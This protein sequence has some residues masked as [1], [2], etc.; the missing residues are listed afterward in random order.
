MLKLCNAS[1]LANAAFLSEKVSILM[2]EIK[3]KCCVQ[4]VS[5]TLTL[6]MMMDILFII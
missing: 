5:L 4:K 2:H 6:Y 3:I 1:F